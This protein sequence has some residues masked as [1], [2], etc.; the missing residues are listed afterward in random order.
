MINSDSIVISWHRL[1]PYAA[2][3]ISTTQQHLPFPLHV[4]ASCPAPQF[5]QEVNEIM[6]EMVT[7][8]DVKQPISWQGLGLKK[9]QVFFQNGWLSHAFNT[10]GKE[11]KK[12]GNTVICLADNSW[13]NTPRQW[14][15]ALR[16][17]SHYRSL[18]DG[19][20]VPGKSGV[21]L[22]KFL[23]M[24][25][26]S[27]YTG[28]YSA[29]PQVFYRTMP[30]RDRPKQFLFVGQLIH[31][32][33]IDL[34]V[35]AFHRVYQQYPDWKLCILGHGSLADSIHHPGIQLKPSQSSKMVAQYM[36]ESR[37]LVLPSRQDHWGL[38]VHEA[39]L[40]G[41]GLILSN[42]VGAGKDLAMS[43]NSFIFQ[44]GNIYALTQ[45]LLSAIHASEIQLDQMQQ[46][47]QRLA[48]QFSPNLWAETLQ[49]LVDQH[50]LK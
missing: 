28:L 13:K 31:R 36:N 20:W 33:G 2:R 34:L 35:E 44:S 43:E 47:S 16:F 22:F 8:I 46:T 26:E 30:L 38:V 49:K 4:I 39:A 27:I 1:P 32:K 37:F 25:E 24:P 9:P 50:F 7:W 23:G 18:F 29:D 45:S 5:L 11:V 48:Q 10:L 17:R 3:L 40:C 14:L 15:G 6:P 19:V 42:A 21:Q 12:Q 41:C